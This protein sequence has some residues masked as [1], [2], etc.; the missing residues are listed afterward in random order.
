MTGVDGVA[1]LLMW[2]LTSFPAKIFVDR[3]TASIL[4]VTL[5]ASSKGI[6]TASDKKLLTLLASRRPNARQYLK[7]LAQN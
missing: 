2:A 4:L 1:W 5:H 7:A 6:V 3:S